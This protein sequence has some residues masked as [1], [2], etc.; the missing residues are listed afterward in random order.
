MMEETLG[1]TDAALAS[2]VL[3]TMR[4]PY[5]V[6][7]YSDI[8]DTVPRDVVPDSR[9]RRFLQNREMWACVVPKK[10]APHH[11]HVKYRHMS[12]RTAWA[13]RW[14]ADLWG[15]YFELHNAAIL[16]SYKHIPPSNGDEDMDTPPVPEIV[17]PEVYKDNPSN[18]RPIL[19]GA[20]RIAYK[21]ELDDPTYEPSESEKEEE[22]APEISMSTLEDDDKKGKET[23]DR[24]TEEAEEDDEEEEDAHGNGKAEAEEDKDEDEDEDED[25]AQSNGKEEDEGEDDIFAEEDVYKVNHIVTHRYR[26]EQTEYLISWE[27]Y[28][29]TYDTWE[30]E[31]NL[32][33]DKLLIDYWLKRNL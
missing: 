28:D 26:D 18:T 32:L 16:D 31:D 9:L 10:M 20:L 3:S 5:G 17:H 13:L 12:G 27:G 8:R 7:L 29:A 4:V 30:P 22:D 23:A 14:L 24:T 6:L 19:G 25:D 1:S 21:D 11:I 2:L 15:P 33:D